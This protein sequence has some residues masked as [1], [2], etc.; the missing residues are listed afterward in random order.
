MGSNSNIHRNGKVRV[1]VLFGGQ[2]DEHDVSL[3]SALTIMGALDPSKYEV[4]PIGITRE[5]R[6]LAG[7]DPIAQLTA[8]SPLFALTDGATAPGQSPVD[9]GVEPG[10]ALPAVLSGDVDVVFPVLHGPMG[11]DGTVQGMLELA[12]VPYVGAGVLG[13]AVAMDKA[14]AKTI[15]A[16]AGVP[17]V[18]WLTVLRRDWERE[19]DVIAQ[20]VAETLGF[21]CFTKPANLGS[22]VGIAKVHGPE[23]LAAGMNEAARFDRK[24]VVEQGVD[25]RE[26]EISVLGNDE[27]VASV[28]GEIVPSNEFYDYHAKYVD[29]RSALL[30][31]ADIPKETLAE[32]QRLAVAAFRALDL[33]GMARVDFF[34]ERGTDRLYVN[35]INTIPGFTS[36]SMYPML[37]GASG[38]PIA[39]LV[40][41]LVDLAVERHGERR[42]RPVG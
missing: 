1:A 27:P 31:P 10:G 25:A 4:M 11:E 36:I 15:L 19:P 26:L 28:A 12:N 21:P 5:G 7:G 39:E 3:R 24:I 16:Q 37:W 6:W 32:M 29:D 40:D 22:S 33:A 34:L 41:R 2:S 17:Q 30:I 20:R 38:V 42:R 18:P 35:E 13:S 8:N 23:E 9:P 14:V